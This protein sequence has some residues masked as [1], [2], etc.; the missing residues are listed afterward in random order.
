MLSLTELL[1]VRLV[2]AFVWSDPL[3]KPRYAVTFQT[4]LITAIWA[5]TTIIVLFTADYPSYVSSVLSPSLNLT[6]TDSITTQYSVDYP[7]PKSV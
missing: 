4:G 7:T 1:S 5:V 3:M 6:H 2:E